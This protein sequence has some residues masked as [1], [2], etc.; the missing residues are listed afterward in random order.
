[1]IRFEQVADGKKLIG[2]G[3]HLEWVDMCDPNSACMTVEACGAGL[4]TF[5]DVLAPKITPSQDM[6]D[7]EFQGLEGPAEGGQ[8][9]GGQDSSEADTSL[10]DDFSGFDMDEDSGE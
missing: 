6:L 3:I 8:A 1:M 9:A 5:G 2:P 7:A 4:M 10:S